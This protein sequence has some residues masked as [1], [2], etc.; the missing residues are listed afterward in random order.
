[1]A[2]GGG[3]HSHGHS[4]ASGALGLAF[5][6]N[7]GFTIFELVGGLLTNSVAILSDAVHDAGDSLSLG[8][9]WL[10]QRVSERE[11]DTNFTYGY[12]RYSV[13]GALTTGVLLVAGLAFILVQA[14]PRL[15]AP[16]DVNAHGM[17]GIAVVGILVNGVAALRLRHGSS[18]NESVASWHLVEDVLGW[19]AVLIGGAA[20]IVWNLP[21]I[22]PILSILISAFVLWNVVKNL[23]KIAAVFLQRVPHGFDT[24]KFILA[25]KS[26]PNVKDVHHTHAWT[27]DG[28]HHVLTTH[29]MLNE[30]TGR[31]EIVA[32]KQKV[33]DL[34]TDEPF[35]HV[36]IDVELAGEPCVS[37]KA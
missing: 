13:L 36:T 10:L 32:T 20:I 30:G 19:I 2:A 31:G 4:K 9:A 8:L 25:V 15:A 23:K 35:E 18:L 14:I 26:L 37:C 11:K 16:V 7:L 27:L 5:F 3:G 17:L 34:I 1:M 24:A 12:S 28:E 21:I 29:I 6:L 22:D 33:R